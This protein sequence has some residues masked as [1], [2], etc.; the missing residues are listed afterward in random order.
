MQV[1]WKFNGFLVTESFNLQLSALS[2]SIFSSYPERPSSLEA[3]E[4]Y[5]K[6]SIPISQN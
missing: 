1:L 2:F 4:W 6:T 5:P 3:L